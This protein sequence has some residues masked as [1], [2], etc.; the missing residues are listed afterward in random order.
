MNKEYVKDCI[1]TDP[2]VYIMQLFLIIL[3]YYLLTRHFTLNAN[4]FPFSWHRHG[5]VVIFFVN[6]FT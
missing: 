2:Q 6:Y 5:Y 1:I 3:K 4:K